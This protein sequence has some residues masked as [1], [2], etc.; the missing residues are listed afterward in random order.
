MPTVVP[1]VASLALM[2]RLHDPLMCAPFEI[3][4]DSPKWQHG[5][6]ETGPLVSQSGP[7]YAAVHRVRHYILQEVLVS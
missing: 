4:F 1:R 6:A 2:A 7:G 5:K 3:L